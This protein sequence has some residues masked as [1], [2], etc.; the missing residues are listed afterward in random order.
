MKRP[1]P[2]TAM[3]W[4]ALPSELGG[5]TSATV[6][7]VLAS[8]TQTAFLVFVA[9]QVVLAFEK[10]QRSPGFGFRTGLPVAFCIGETITPSRSD[11]FLASRFGPA[12]GAP[13]PGG[14]TAGAWA[15]TAG[16]PPGCWTWM[17]PGD[18]PPD[19]G[20]RVE[21]AAASTAAPPTSPP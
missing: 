7:L 16:R 9:P 10:N 6:F 11:Q 12:D 21:Q 18:L 4:L 5:A 14:A 20:A 13:K 19:C 17:G 8:I 2:E 15:A 3:P 1:S